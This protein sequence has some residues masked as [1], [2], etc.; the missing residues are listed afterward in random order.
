MDNTHIV[1]LLIEIKGN[2]GELT[3][4]ARIAERDRGE[5]KKLLEDHVSVDLGV[6][7]R[8]AS[9]ESS[10]TKMRGM[11]VGFSLIASVIG[12]IATLVIKAIPWPQ[13]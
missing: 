1:A 7:A 13:F 5:M 2:V 9:L 8:V 4:S 3:T 6:A 10:R 12:T 11:V